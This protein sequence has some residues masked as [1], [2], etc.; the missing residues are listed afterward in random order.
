M[1]EIIIRSYKV[2]RQKMLKIEVI[3]VLNQMKVIFVSLIDIF[4]K[5]VF[6]K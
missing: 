3:S 1:F 6:G 2:K 4:V 5:G